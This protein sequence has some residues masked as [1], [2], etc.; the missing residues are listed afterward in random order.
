MTQTGDLSKLHTPPTAKRPWLSADIFPKL[1]AST[2]PGNVRQL[3]N[4]ASQ[5]AISNRSAAYARVSPEL[6][7]SIAREPA[8]PASATRTPPKTDSV[9]HQAL[10][11]AMARHD[12]QPAKVARALKVS[13]T[14]VYDHMRRDPNLGLLSRL[15]DEEFLRHVADCNGDLEQVAKRLRASYRAVQLRYAQFSAA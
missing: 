4:F 2:W 14:T 10:V 1:V 7:A 15:S 6:V 5:L 8:G 11:E 3:R 9:S 13:R 12:Y